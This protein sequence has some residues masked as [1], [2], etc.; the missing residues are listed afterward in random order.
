MPV[1]DDAIH[2]PSPSDEIA[3]LNGLLAER[4]QVITRYQSTLSQHAST[5]TQYESTI[6]GHLS[7]I[8]QHE[9]TIATLTRER[10]EYQ[11]E[12][13]RLE[14]RVAQLLKRAYGPRA[15]RVGN[16]AQLLLDFAKELESQPIQPQDLPP[17]DGAAKDQ[18]QDK[19]RTK[20]RLRTRGRRDI[21][22]LNHLPM[23][24]QKYDLT[25][26]ACLCPACRQ[27]REKIGEEISYTVEY[28]PGS[29][30]RIKHIQCKYAC[31]ACE[32]QGDNPNI[33]RADKPLTRPDMNGEPDKTGASPIDK[34]LPGPALLAYIATAKYADYLPLHRLEVIFERQGFELDRS[35]MCLWMAD[36]ARIVRPVYDR[37]V[38]RVLQSHVLAT[39]DTVMPLLQP[40]RAKQARMWVY[41]GDEDHPYN[42][43][44]FTPNR[45]RDGPKKFLK[46]FRQTL[47]A[48]AYGGYDGIVLDQELPR[49]GCW[50]HARRKFV[51]AEPVAPQIARDILKQIK[52][53]FDIEERAKS[54]SHK[55][56]LALRGV[57]SQPIIETLHGL[58]HE[59]KAALLPKH[60]MAEAIGYVLNQWKELTL[61]L[62][63]G[64]VPIHNNLAEQQ[65]KRI[66]LLRKNALFVA[67][68]RGGETAAILSSFTSTCRRHDINPQAYL[69]QLLVNL[70]DTP[71][72]RLDEW[73][74][75]EWTKRNA[76]P[77]QAAA[78]PS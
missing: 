39:D 6:A 73:L 44:D 55:D 21:G 10:D 69:T 77:P 41:L 66:A 37:M 59:H 64:A 61:F 74:P 7:T 65:M 13:L 40:R 35:T 20:R 25:G 70:Q 50:S 54:L 29:F 18:T 53:L 19:P 49:A 38:Q 75:D 78:T 24:E 57:E 4:D 9:S 1:T 60:P 63:D 14:M 23:I 36:V 46:E 16:V 71:I 28:L 34:G 56:R 17:A 76:P 67:T 31:G 42:V 15:D 12:K 68:A 30:I 11:L 58:M 48:D 43:F 8:T 51:D 45:S 33:E 22:S 72:S 26:D 47:L 62:S 3:R 27:Q 2:F 32:Q 5:I 52:G